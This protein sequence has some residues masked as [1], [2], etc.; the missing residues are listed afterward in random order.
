MPSPEPL[1]RSPE[2]LSRRRFLARGAAVGAAALSSPVWELGTPAAAGSRKV[3]W[4]ALCQPIS[5]QSPQQAIASL[6]E[7]VGRKFSVTHHR[8]PWTTPLVNRVTS[9]AVNEGHTP[10]ISWFAR[11]WPDRELV[12]FRRIANGDYDRWITEQARNLRRAGWSGYFCFHKEPE[13]ETNADDWKDAYARVRRIFRNVGVTRFRWIVCLIASTYG[14]GEA[15]QWMPSADWDLVGADANN[16]YRCG[17]APWKSFETLFEAARRFARRRERRLF[18]VEYA[19]VE[20]SSG[21]K[22]QWIDDARATIKDW[23]EMAGVCYLHEDSDCSYWVDSS[24]SSLR[25]FREM[26]RDRRFR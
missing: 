13:D 25:A 5:G 22:A 15:D 16:R 19:S 1:G 3:H 6:E 10:V 9:W 18:V 17:G 11:T 21:Q 24:R 26:G 14:R 7:K 2:P 20:G 4:G 8:L 12:G 23:P